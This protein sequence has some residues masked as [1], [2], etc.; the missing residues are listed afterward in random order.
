MFNCRLNNRTALVMRGRAGLM[1]RLL[2]RNF[3]RF[4][5]VERLLPL[6]DARAIFRQALS[7]GALDQ[8]ASIHPIKELD[9]RSDAGS[10][11]APSRTTSRGHLYLGVLGA[12]LMAG[13]PALLEQEAPRVE[14]LNT[15]IS[16][17]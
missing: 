10:K 9:T 2:A 1:V 17:S 4:G 6:D 14:V 3:D 12:A 8:F 5:D 15:V 16:G 7:D 13:I 11:L